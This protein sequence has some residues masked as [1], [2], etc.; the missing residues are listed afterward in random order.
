MVDG[1]QNQISLLGKKTAAVTYMQQTSSERP[2]AQIIL[3]KEYHDGKK[4]G[5]LRRPWQEGL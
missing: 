5:V 4:F 2:S 3:A 1:D